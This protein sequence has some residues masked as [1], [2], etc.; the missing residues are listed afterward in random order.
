M[1][2]FNLIVDEK[3][4]VWERLYV[5]VKAESQA[6]ALAKCMDGDYDIDDSEILYETMEDIA[7]S[8]SEP[9]TVEIFDENDTLLLDNSKCI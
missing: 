4:T 6:E 1:E 3:R 9:V 2:V 7:P 5:S 8:E